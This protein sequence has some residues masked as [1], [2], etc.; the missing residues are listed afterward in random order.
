MFTKSKVIII[1][2]VGALVIIGSGVFV[3]VSNNNSPNSDAQTDIEYTDY[4]PPDSSIP[5]GIKNINDILNDK[6][7]EYDSLSLTVLDAS[8]LVISN[9]SIAKDFFIEYSDAYDCTTIKESKEDKE[10]LK[11]IYHFE[12]EDTNQYAS[13]VLS[14]ISNYTVGNSSNITFTEGENGDIEVKVE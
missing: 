1:S 6:I 5:K 9:S 10:P 2:I 13:D 14:Y 7:S 4:I 8:T 11:I 12:E 3:Y